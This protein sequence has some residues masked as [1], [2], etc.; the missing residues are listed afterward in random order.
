MKR[1][2]IALLAIPML[3][4]LAGCSGSA[5]ST[6]TAPKAVEDY[7]QALVTQDTAKLSTLSCKDWEKQAL[8]EL[9]SFQGVTAKVTQPDC[10]Q[11]GTDGNTVLVTCQGKIDATYNNENQQIPLGGRSYKVVQESGEWHVCG[12]K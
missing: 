8:L 5:G 12:Y 7:L 9:D 6:G 11:T 10:A 1:F 4:A 2:L 3:L